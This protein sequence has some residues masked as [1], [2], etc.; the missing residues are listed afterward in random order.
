LGQAQYK[1]GGA[2]LDTLGSGEE[3][4]H[5]GVRSLITLGT[6]HTPPPPDKVRRRRLAGGCA[7]G[8]ALQAAFQGGTTNL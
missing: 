4:P 3:E 5:G 2:S 8:A 7:A 6:P 1:D